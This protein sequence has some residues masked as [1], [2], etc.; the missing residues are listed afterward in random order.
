M[1]QHVIPRR[2]VFLLLGL[3]VLFIAVALFWSH[4]KPAPL[5]PARLA[6]DPARGPV[7]APITIIEYA[8][9]G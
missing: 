9:F 4:P 3:F 1:I 6:D 2:G 7:N 8:D 5:T